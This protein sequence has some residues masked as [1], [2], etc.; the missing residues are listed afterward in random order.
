MN[1]AVTRVKAVAED[2]QSILQRPSARANRAMNGPMAR[3][4]RSLGAP[5]LSFMLFL[6]AWS[7]IAGH[8]KVNFGSIPGPLAV[9][10]QAVVL[11]DD[12]WAERRKEGK[13]YQELSKR[14]ADF[15]AQ[16]PGQTFPR[17]KYSG[18][19]TFLDQICTSL[20]TVFAGFLIGSLIAVPMGIIC[21]LSRTFSSAVNPFIQIFKPVS[22][23]AWLPIVMIMVSALYNPPHPWFEKAFVSSALTV[24]HVFAVADAHQHGVRR[25]APLTRIISTS[26]AC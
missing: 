17:V 22:P 6:F 23:L 18:P 13:F 21:G 12:H 4:L 8:V 10:Q 14:R 24:A 16:H 15:L 20:E 9:W 3:F 26:P 19:P 25:R 2:E 7:Q 11:W 5:V 1:E